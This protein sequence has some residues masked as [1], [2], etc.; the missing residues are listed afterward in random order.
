MLRGSA[1]NRRSQPA[2]DPHPKKMATPG[3][4]RGTAVTGSA[5]LLPGDGLLKAPPAS[6][7]GFLRPAAVSAPRPVVRN[8]AVGK[9][10]APASPGVVLDSGQPAVTT[11]ANGANDYGLAANLGKLMGGNLFFSFSQFDLATAESATFSGPASVQNVLARVTG[12]SASSIDGT[13]RSTIPGANLFLMNPAGVMFG[14]NAK[15]DI[16]GSFVV[17]TADYVKLADG[18]KFNAKPGGD[19]VLTSAGVSAFGFLSASPQAVSFDHAHLSVQPGSGLHIIAGDVSGNSARLSAPSGALTVFSAKAA[20]EVPFDPAKPGDGYAGA[21]FDALGS[22]AFRNQSAV[23]IDGAGGGRIVVRGGNLDLTENSA[24]TAN[25]AGSAPGG[26]IDIQLGG[27]LTIHEGRIEANTSGLGDGGRVKI[28]ADQTRIKG[29]YA[30]FITDCTTE[31]NSPTI[32]CPEDHGLSKGMVVSARVLPGRTA[33]SLS[34][35][36][37]EFDIGKPIYE[38]K[39]DGKNPESIDWF[40]FK[41]GS[42]LV[43]C[44]DTTGL[45]AGMAVSGTNIPRNATIEE[46]VDSTRFRISATST[47]PVNTQQAFELAGY[48]PNGIFTLVDRAN[49]QGKG[50]NISIASRALSIVGNGQIAADTLGMGRG[51]RVTIKASDLR[52]TG[53]QDL[54]NNGIF[55]TVQRGASG[56]GGT[57]HVNSSTVSIVGNGQISTSTYGNGDGGSVTVSAG[58]LSIEGGQSD[59]RIGQGIFARATKSDSTGSSGTITIRS[60]NISLLGDGSRIAV[61]CTSDGGNAGTILVTATEDIL[62]DSQGAVKHAAAIFASHGVS[63]GAGGDVTVQCGRLDVVGGGQIAST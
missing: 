50:G 11:N 30:K 46:V 17:S 38:L 43:T 31:L 55:S 51:G 32:T 45:L 13:L 23:S 36:P 26:E 57:V 63:D 41:A 33:I 16:S 54:V 44:N 27:T 14:P 8:G 48:A 62:I 4:V 37:T 53:S 10:A 12:G 7:F 5:A 3:A 47:G 28:V 42:D 6:A 2:N 39:I 21:P 25:N 60:D 24:I 52:I 18:G 59:L 19:D 49:A 61:S 22:V 56:K 40:R 34:G 15:L 20:G 1:A 29:D 35:N 58:S 9:N